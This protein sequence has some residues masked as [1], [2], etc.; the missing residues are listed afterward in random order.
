MPTLEFD[1][2]A[3]SYRIRFRY[4]GRAFKR[5]LHTASEKLAR[6]AATRIE[7]TLMLV[8]AGRLEKVLVETAKSLMTSCAA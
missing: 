8:A 7:E 3:K 5:S 4:S 6:A 1:H 2:D